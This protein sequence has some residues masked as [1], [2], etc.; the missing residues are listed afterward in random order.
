MYIINK[1]TYRTHV[2]NAN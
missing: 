1:C 2:N